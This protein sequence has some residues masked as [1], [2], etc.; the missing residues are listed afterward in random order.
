VASMSSHLLL[1]GRDISMSDLRG[2]AYPLDELREE[3]LT[4]EI[5][6]NDLTGVFLRLARKYFS[7]SG[8]YSEPPY[9]VL[10][11]WYDLFGGDLIAFSAAR[12]EQRRVGKECC[13]GSVA[14]FLT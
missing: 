12:S 9:E 2:T 13:I 3:A 7:L 14:F 1:L 4:L 8:Y 11:H 10:R 6:P 5:R